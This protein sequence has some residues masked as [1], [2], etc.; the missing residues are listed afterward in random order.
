MRWSFAALVC[1]VMMQSAG[2]FAMPDDAALHERVRAIL[3]EVPLIDGH[4]DVPWQ[5]RMRVSNHVDA[6]DFASDLSSLG[7]QTDIP[8]LREGMVGG[9]FWSVFIPIS[10]R[11]GRPGDA[12]T[13]IE[14]IDLV[15]RLIA[16]HPNDLEL[17]LTA[18]DIVRI[19][20]EGRIASLMGM[21]GGHSIENSLAVLR[22]TYNLGARY[23]T[24]T[25]WRNTDWA[26][27]ATDA[28]IHNG[29]TAFGREV[30]REMNRLGMMVDLSHVSPATMADAIEVSRAPIIFSH[31]SAFEV[32]RHPRN[33][34]D[35]VLELTRKNGGIVMICFLGSF[36]SE[37][38]R[39]WEE[40]FSEERRRLVQLHR[41]DRDA[42]ERDLA[43]WREVN[44]QPHA[45]L[46][47]VADHIDHVRAVAGIDHV[48]IGGDYDG[49]TSLPIGL[50]DVSTYPALFVELLKR[51]YS[52]E[53][54]A[55]IAGLNM[56]RVMREVER[57]AAELQ[58]TTP[59]S[60][61][62]I[63]ELDQ[64]LPDPAGRGRRSE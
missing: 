57:V 18:D 63:E 45:T 13:V 7:M 39:Q 20:K 5:Y 32:C 10:M 28:P 16:R 31:S 64:P 42:I 4:N 61:A 22:A 24:L 52:D 51:G 27:A 44:P 34:P 2:A 25:H 6:M 8:R 23:M 38:L 58:A 3:R 59:P 62:L 33:V 49:T 53:D 47:E 60:S 37:H 9:Q 29:L 50:E 46:E 55:K 36:V 48:G 14:Q 1:A 56:L 19:H 12:R 21:E 11:G 54:V 30:V 41:E 26:D 43:A 40:H 35:D 15:H 17:A